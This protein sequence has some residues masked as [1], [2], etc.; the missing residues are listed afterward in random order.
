M[1]LRGP[2]GDL[3]ALVD[4][5][6]PENAQPVTAVFCH[7]VGEHGNLHN[8]VTQIME[9]ACRE[10][11]ARTVRF[12]FRGVGRSEGSFDHGNG[13]TEDLLTV[14]SWVRRVRPRDELWLGGN[15]FGAYVVLRACQKLAPAQ[16][17]TISLP[18]DEFDFE[19]LPKP[20]CPWLLIHAD[21]DEAVP[22]E[23]LQ[24]WVET[25][26]TA[27]QLLVMEDTDPTFHRR[28]MDLRGA[29]KNGI[30]RQQP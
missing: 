8:K 9:R 20:E 17:V 5:P 27:P 2:A 26:A 18:L 28:L 25:L 12:D 6:E 13:E 11:G 21:E 1:I 22:R 24:A 7:P 30:K 10:L 3:G 15:E 14:A 23:Q 19:A 16:L 29:I 4:L